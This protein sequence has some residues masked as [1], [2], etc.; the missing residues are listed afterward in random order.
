M[1]TNR[2]Y[3]LHIYSCRLKT[4]QNQINSEL[5]DHRIPAFK[6]EADGAPHLTI[7]GTASTSDSHCFTI[8]K[9]NPQCEKRCSGSEKAQGRRHGNRNTFPTRWNR[10]EM[11]AETKGNAILTETSPTPENRATLA[12]AVVLELHRGSSAQKHISAP[13]E[14]LSTDRNTTPI[15]LKHRATNKRCGS[16]IHCPL[17][18]F[19]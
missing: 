6:C 17:S 19:Y 3:G 1:Q 15:V 7:L 13:C 10:K 4:A 12:S 5:S 16:E 9:P 11:D 2:I 14:C 8:K 18:P